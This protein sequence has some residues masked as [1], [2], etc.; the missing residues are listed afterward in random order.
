MDT[1]ALMKEESSVSVPALARRAVETYVLTGEQIQT[2]ENVLEIL[3]ARAGCFVSIKMRDGDLR[4]CIGTIEPA[5]QNLADEIIMNAINAANRDPRFSPVAAEELP[6]L[7]YSVDILAP[8]EPAGIE[9]LDP[10]TY[11]VIVENE[12]GTLRGLLL[13]AIEGVDSVEQQ[14]SIAAR[15][16]GI[17]QGLPLKLWRFR[18]DRF[19]EQ[20]ND[21][22]N[23]MKQPIRAATK[24]NDDAP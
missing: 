21:P 6:N 11:G 7:V 3:T 24:I 15:K 13:P 10:R 4:G 19:R 18:V 2:P 17:P 23:C 8:A 9:D 14:V 16:A 22:L 1:S 12:A 5:K 20:T